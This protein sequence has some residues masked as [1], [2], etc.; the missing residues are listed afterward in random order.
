MSASGRQQTCRKDSLLTRR[1]ENPDVLLKPCLYAMSA[2]A[3]VE[4]PITWRPR[5]YAA[6]RVSME[7]AALL[8]ELLVSRVVGR[9]LR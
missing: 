9:A 1:G 5:I 3:V 4:R 6:R 2:K 8:T 7:A